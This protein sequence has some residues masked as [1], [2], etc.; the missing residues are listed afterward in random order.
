MKKT[1]G[2][3]VMVGCDGSGYGFGRNLCIVRRSYKRHCPSSTS[4]KRVILNFRLSCEA[5]LR[6][7]KEMHDMLA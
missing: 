4:K 3:V 5:I 2:T 1:Q 6:F 7:I